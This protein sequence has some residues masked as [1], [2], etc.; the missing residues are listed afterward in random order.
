LT[1]YY[2]FFS[3]IVPIFSLAL[4]KE[5]H[6]GCQSQEEGIESSDLNQ[7]EDALDI[8][9]NTSITAIDGIGA[10]KEKQKP[11]NFFLEVSAV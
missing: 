5:Q 2:C 7:Q 11:Q 4:N 3:N 8:S 10:E 6:D 1:R 9:E